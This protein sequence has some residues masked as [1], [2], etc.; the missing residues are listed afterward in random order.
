M[1]ED[2]LYFVWKTKY[3]SHEDLFT[4]D[5]EP[6]KILDYGR[7]NPYSG[8]DFSNAKIMIADTLWV[9]NVEMHILSSDWTKH[10][11]E[12]DDS[13]QNVILHVVYRHDKEINFSNSQPKINIPTLE[14]RHKI[15]EEILTRYTSLFENQYWIPCEKLICE[16]DLSKLEVWKSRLVIERLEHKVNYILPIYQ[17]S[18]DDWETVLYVI[19]ARYFGSLA[20]M[21]SFEALARK[22]D[23]RIV[24]KN[25]HDIITIEALFFGQ[26]GML[27]G[28]SD[29]AYITTLKEKYSFLKKKYNLE[30]LPSSIWKYS[31]VMPPGFP[32]LRIG[33][34]A[35]LIATKHS[36]FSS[37]LHCHDV[38]DLYDSLEVQV[39]TFWSNHYTFEKRSQARNT[40]LS[41][42]F[43]DLLIMNAII[44]VFFLYGKLT[45]NQECMDKFVNLLSEVKGEKNRV[46]DQWRNLGLNTS[47]ALDS[48]A[49]LQ[50]KQSYCDNRKCMSCALGASI[51]KGEHI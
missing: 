29:E 14:L 46:V 11:H 34:F 3:F 37:F 26:A 35:S 39:N 45:G 36:L 33:Q 12:S 6:I 50:L 48:Q 27:E 47:T 43:K 49:L 19:L 41:K 20:N 30:P 18:N 4:T 16:I 13:Y 7:Q 15:P 51:M 2:L 40:K 21:E 10:N 1:K 31:G 38:H 28:E 42:E 25:V 8:P 22:V 32:T 9:G 23:K 17:E 24:L 44:P 5:G